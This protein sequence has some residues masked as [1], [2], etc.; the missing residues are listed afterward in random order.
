M[1][2]FPTSARRFRHALSGRGTT[3]VCAARGRLANSKTKQSRASQP[4]LGWVGAHRHQRGITPASLGSCSTCD[5]APLAFDLSYGGGQHLAP[6]VNYLTGLDLHAAGNCPQP[7]LP[8]RLTHQSLDQSSQ[9]TRAE[10]LGCLCL[11]LCRTKKRARKE[12]AE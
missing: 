10:L 1:R 5:S 3:A 7:L 11:D 2:L 4:R 8:R 6:L 12:R 9:S